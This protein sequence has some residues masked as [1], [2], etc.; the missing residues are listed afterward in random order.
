MVDLEDGVDVGQLSL[1]SLKRLSLKV[2]ENGYGE[3]EVSHVVGVSFVED[4]I[5]I[6]AIVFIPELDFGSGGGIVSTHQSALD[7]YGLDTVYFLK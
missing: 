3:V 6:W 1:R 5:R 4:I 2:E 7:G